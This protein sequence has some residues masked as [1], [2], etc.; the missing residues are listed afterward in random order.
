MVQPAP[1]NDNCHHFKSPLFELLLDFLLEPFRLQLI[2]LINI[3][4][5]SIA[6]YLSDRF[7]RKMIK[8]PFLIIAG[9]GGAVSGW[10]SWKMDNPF[11]I[12]LLGRVLQGIGSAGAAPVSRRYV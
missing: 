3:I 9:I 12:I 11:I 2:L 8:V 6:G 7:G 1:I 10:A 5:P 4:P